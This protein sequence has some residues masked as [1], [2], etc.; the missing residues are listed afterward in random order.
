MIFLAPA[1]FLLVA[2]LLTWLDAHLDACMWAD[3]RD[4]GWCL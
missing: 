4:D 2:G 3:A 1:V